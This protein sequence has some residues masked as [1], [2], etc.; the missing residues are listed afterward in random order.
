MKFNNK[1]VE[2]TI[3]NQ[4]DLIYK[5]ELFEV[6]E[7]KIEGGLIATVEDL[8]EELTDGA[9]SI[10][11]RLTPI[12]YCDIKEDFIKLIK[13]NMVNYILE[14]YDIEYK[15]DFYNYMQ[16]IIFYSILDEVYED[17]ER[18]IENSIIREID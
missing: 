12:Y 14:N 10:A 2:V 13:E 11:D 5:N 17:V 1:E 7:Q 18:I 16:V 3:N 15:D 9:F 4:E 8:R 6:I